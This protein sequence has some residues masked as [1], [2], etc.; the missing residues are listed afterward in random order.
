MQ[1]NI[2]HVDYKHKDL[3]NA[4]ALNDRN[5]H[6]QIYNLYYKAMYNTIQNLKL[7]KLLKK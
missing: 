7:I 1:K 6:M 5:A 3:V 4:C 2:K